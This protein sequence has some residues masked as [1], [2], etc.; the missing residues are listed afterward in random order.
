MEREATS[1]NSSWGSKFLSL[2][3]R[4]WMRF[5]WHGIY[6][7]EGA[8]LQ[9][10]RATTKTQLPVGT[11]L[12]GRHGAELCRHMVSRLRKTT[13][14][15]LLPVSL[16]RWGIWGSVR[17]NS[18]DKAS[19]LQL[20]PGLADSKVRVHNL[21]IKVTKGNIIGFWKILWVEKRACVSYMPGLCPSAHLAV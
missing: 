15:E 16:S 6:R 18:S 13:L 8:K 21:H 17:G 19:G 11:W 3:G 5:T 14:D 2:S 12:C 7:W 10:I 9:P 1:K 4:T 20:N